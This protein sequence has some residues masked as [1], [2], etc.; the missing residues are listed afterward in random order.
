MSSV[1][2]TVR[3]QAARE[4]ERKIPDRMTSAGIAA[5]TACRSGRVSARRTSTTKGKMRNGPKTF[6]S[7]KPPVARP[8]LVNISP[9]SPK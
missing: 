9:A 5:A 6:G 4:K 7:W 8:N 3:P 2:T 1:A